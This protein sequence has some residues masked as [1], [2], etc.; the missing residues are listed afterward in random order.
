[1]NHRV[2][3]IVEQRRT[4]WACSIIDHHR[5]RRRIVSQ[6]LNSKKRAGPLCFFPC[7]CA[8]VHKAAIYTGL[9]VIPGFFAPFLDPVNQ[10]RGSQYSSSGYDTA[11][12]QREARTA[13]QQQSSER[14]DSFIL[15]MA[16]APLFVESAR[17]GDL[18]RQQDDA[19]AL[20]LEGITEQEITVQDA[21]ALPSY[22]GEQ[23]YGLYNSS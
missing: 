5:Q 10:T 8:L 11:R 1:M 12:Q 17:Y 14:D 22:A 19:D 13:Q 23:Q 4:E 3:D 20:D 21:E 6:I 9:I 18:V 2:D 16:T 15:T 7:S